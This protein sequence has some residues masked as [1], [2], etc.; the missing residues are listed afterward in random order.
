MNKKKN[1]V[2]KIERNKTYCKPY[3]VK[4]ELVNTIGGKKIHATICV[5]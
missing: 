4:V 2:Y 1:E 3:S 5:Y